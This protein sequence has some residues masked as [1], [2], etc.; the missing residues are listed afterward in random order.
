MNRIISTWLMAGLLACAGLAQAETRI[1]YVNTQ[2]IL[3]DAPQ[4]AKA[5]KKIEKEFEKRDQE[6]TRLARQLKTLQESIE[7]SAV[8]MTEAD[9]RGK[10]RELG[11]LGREFQRRQ[12]EFNED[13]NLRQNEEMAA[14]FDRLNK[15]IKSVAEAEKYDLIIQDA[16]FASPRIDITDRVIKVLG[17]P[18]GK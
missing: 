6:L 17:E 11:E 4:A 1:G 10:E 16:I 18:A 9:R 15:A 7:K 3:A 13:M 8:T 14:I 5:K 12:R 2:R